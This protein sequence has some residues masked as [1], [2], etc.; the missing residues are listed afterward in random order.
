MNI[1]LAG[2]NRL[3]LV[4]HARA[5]LLVLVKFLAVITIICAAPV[6]AWRC[7]FNLLDSGHVVLQ[8]GYPPSVSCLTRRSRV[9]VHALACFLF[10]IPFLPSAGRSMSP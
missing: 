10:N 8:I 1:G 2:I 9:R 4:K 7:C 6:D 3:D 5:F